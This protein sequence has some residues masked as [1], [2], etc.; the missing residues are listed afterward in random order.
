V[1]GEQKL[2]VW[3]M[4]V[5]GATIIGILLIVAIWGQG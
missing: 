2:W 5:C 1:S 4:A 3:S